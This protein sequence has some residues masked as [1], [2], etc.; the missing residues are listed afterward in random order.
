MSTKTLEFI[1]GDAKCSPE[2]Q[3]AQAGSRAR[4]GSGG[5]KDLCIVVDT[6]LNVSQESTLV[7]EKRNHILDYIR[8]RVSSRLREVIIPSPWHWGGMH[9]SRKLFLHCS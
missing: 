3:R 4:R 9:R 5:G 7:V 2:V 1:R 8:R 6:G